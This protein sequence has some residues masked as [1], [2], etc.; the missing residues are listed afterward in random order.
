VVAHSYISV[1]YIYVK[2]N[3]VL[4]EV[5]PQGFKKLFA[6]VVEAAIANEARLR[7]EPWC[8]VRIPSEIKIKSVKTF[9]I[10]L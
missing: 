5:H 6:A 4:L 8:G 2:C 10:Q 7:L 1:Q 3:I 9:M